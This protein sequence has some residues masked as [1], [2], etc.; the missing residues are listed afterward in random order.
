MSPQGFPGTGFLKNLN[1]AKEYPYRVPSMLARLRVE[2]Q[3]RLLEEMRAP[4]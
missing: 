1:T 2:R 3:L 4:G